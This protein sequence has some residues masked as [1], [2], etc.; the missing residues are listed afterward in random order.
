M[1]YEPNLYALVLRLV[2]EKGHYIPD[3]Y[4]QQLHGLF[5]ELVRQVDPEQSND[6]H[7]P[8]LSKHFTLAEVPRYGRREDFRGIEIRITLLRSVLF[9]TLAQA[10]M[11]QSVRPAMRIGP[12]PMLLQDVFGT[13]GTHPW[14]GYSRFEDLVE[15]VQVDKTVT[16]EFKTAT[17]IKQGDIEDSN[18]QRLQTLPTPEAVFGSLAR[19]WNDLAPPDL[20]LPDSKD[21]FREIC[22]NILVKRYSLET[23]VQRLRKNPQVGFV[24]RCTYELPNNP[25]YQRTLTLL[26]DA[27]F[28]MGL[29]AKTSQGM[30]MCRRIRS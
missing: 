23:N 2:S 4:G 18:K 29:G 3:A 26:A 19:R 9:Q 7:K 5:M 28:Y 16:L 11:E 25:A 22:K 30:G 20:L 24:G 8:A 10:L 13:P 27:A 1:L 21:D 6:L 14:A 17:F 15:Q 12:T